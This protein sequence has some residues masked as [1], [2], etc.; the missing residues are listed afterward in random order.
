M[1]TLIKD[2]DETET[3]HYYRSTDIEDTKEK[4]FPPVQICNVKNDNLLSDRIY[5][6]RIAKGEKCFKNNLIPFRP[7]FSGDCLPKIHQKPP[8]PIQNPILPDCCSNGL[9]PN[10]GDHLGYL[11]NIDIESNLQNIATK[12]NKCANK[13]FKTNLSKKCKD[14]CCDYIKKEPVYQYPNIKPDKC[15]NF[16]TLNKCDKQSENRFQKFDTL[17]DYTNHEICNLGCEKI[18]NTRSKRNS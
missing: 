5:D 10:C 8:E 13:E 16:E 11:A 12:T 6:R 17:Y 14:K 4:W 7:A 9:W 15:I 18:W 1:D 2:N 3:H